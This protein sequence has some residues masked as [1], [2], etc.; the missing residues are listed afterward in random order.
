MRRG[1]DWSLLLLIA[2]FVLVILMA[3]AGFW[4]HF[5]APCDSPFFTLGTVGDLPA[6]CLHP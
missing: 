5:A 1:G 2:G 4:V 3:V 6:R